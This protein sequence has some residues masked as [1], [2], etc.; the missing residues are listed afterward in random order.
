LKRCVNNREFAVEPPGATSWLIW[1]AVPG[2]YVIWWLFGCLLV[3]GVY[4]VP[5]LLNTTAFSTYAKGHF[6]VHMTQ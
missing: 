6:R 1:H 4:Q 2:G 5:T 3:Y